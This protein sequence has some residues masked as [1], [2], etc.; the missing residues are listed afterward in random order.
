MISTSEADLTGATK[1]LAVA[2]TPLYLVRK[3]RHDQAVIDI[4]CSVDAEA[5]LQ[6]IRD[7][8]SKA[9]PEPVDSVRPYVYLVALAMKQESRWLAEASEIHAPDWNWYRY[10]AKYLLDTHSP[11]MNQTIAAGRYVPNVSI[12]TQ[13]PVKTLILQPN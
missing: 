12:Q 9:Q 3:L 2:N 10:I 5:I 1:I 6:S 11:V 4:G 7:A 8:V 13:S